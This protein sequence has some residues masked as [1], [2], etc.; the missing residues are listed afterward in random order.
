MA[1]ADLRVDWATH[2]AAKY[3]V[4]NWH[5]SRSMAVGKIVKVG[6]WES[7]KFIGVVLFA[8]GANNNI[9]K[10]FG[11]AQ[12]ACCEL[13]RVALHKHT[14]PVSQIV[15][16]ALRMLKRTNPGIRL[17][18]SYADTQQG[19]HGGIYQAGNWV[20]T[21][22]S[23]GAT[24]YVL[25]GRIV[26]SMQIQTFIRA[27]KLKSRAG[28]ETV[29]AGDKHKYLMPLDA[30]MRERILPL[31]KPYPKRAKQAING[32]QPS[33]RQGSTDPHAPKVST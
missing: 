23:D 28:L 26:H 16:Q 9:G 19:H 14:T 12:T 31:S 25:N 22:T 30:E 6:A 17:V 20:F 13:V 24:Q 2:E 32:D 11:L 18:I 1:K 3:A 4:L 27:G 5:Y 8:Y 15:A 21:G 29:T 10:P 33:E 7:G